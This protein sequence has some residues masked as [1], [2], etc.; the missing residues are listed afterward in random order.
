MKIVSAD[1]V[2]KLIKS[3]DIVAI[4][5]SGG[6]GSPD[7]V[8]QAIQRRY[9]A[10]N[11]P[12]NLTVTSGI[13]PGNLTM[14]DVGMNCL[15]EKGLVGKAICAHLGMGKK[16]GNAIGENQFP[17]F[18][19]PL[20]VYTHLLRATAGHKPGV[21]G[22]AQAAGTGSGCR[23]QTRRAGHRLG[24]L[25]TGSGCW[26]QARGARREGSPHHE[27]AL[28]QGQAQVLPMPCHS[29]PRDC[30][31]AGSCRGPAARLPRVV[32]WEPGP[33]REVDRLSLPA[34]FPFPEARGESRPC[35]SPTVWFL[36]LPPVEEP[37]RTPGGV[38]ARPARALPGVSGI[39]P[40]Q[41]CPA[42]NL[43]GDLT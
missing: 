5:G 35:S 26:T 3:G 22:Q 9:K 28:A 6:S 13:S 29:R 16:F 12:K 30:R 42:Q 38:G 14:D 10:T 27:P 31:Q 23:G 11:Q 34:A 36:T 4:S 43:R 19:I 8:L 40:T 7:A 41:S 21:L 2:V 15:A 37:A 33:W 25:D 24:V 20:G 17:A 39:P 1:E 18:G 32:Q